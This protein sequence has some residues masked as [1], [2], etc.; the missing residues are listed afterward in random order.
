[1]CTF[2][3]ASTHVYE[4]LFL[5]VEIINN[6]MMFIQIDMD[7]MHTGFALYRIAPRDD[8]PD[9]CHHLL[10]C[11]NKKNYHFAPLAKPLNRQTHSTLSLTHTLTHTRI[12]ARCRKQKKHRKYSMFG[13]I[14]TLVNTVCQCTSTS[15]LTGK[16]LH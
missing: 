11:Y 10:I 1:M 5:I 12:G 16:P 14:F 9:H 7:V 6:L 3:H 8:G 4:M 13:L 15:Y 2:F